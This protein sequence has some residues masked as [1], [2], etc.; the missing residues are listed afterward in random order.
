MQIIS[1]LD[2]SIASVGDQ[3]VWSIRL[4]NI[5]N[6]VY[7]GLH[8]SCSNS[9]GSDNNSIIDKNL[10]V[11]NYTNLFVCGSDVFPS[12]GFTNPTWTIMTLGTRLSHFL[13]KKFG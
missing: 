13:N 5:E 10:K 8:P 3:V 9:M 4:N 1:E 11:K 6:K 7:V 2:T 12:N